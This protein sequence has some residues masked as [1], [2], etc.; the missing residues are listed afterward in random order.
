MNIM[1]MEELKAAIAGIS[2]RVD[3]LETK[4]EYNGG[5]FLR[6]TNASML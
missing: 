1:E 5:V 2:A 4:V 3:N 6:S